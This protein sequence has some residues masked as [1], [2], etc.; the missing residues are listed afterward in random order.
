[1]MW[2]AASLLDWISTVSLLHRLTCYS[3]RLN[4]S[5]PS[6]ASEM[7]QSTHQPGHLKNRVHQHTQ[8]S[9]LFR[10]HKRVMMEWLQSTLRRSHSII[11]RLCTWMDEVHGDVL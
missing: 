10:V 6:K 7:N 5:V 9:V 8:E 11:L 2:G 1:M 4:V 3:P